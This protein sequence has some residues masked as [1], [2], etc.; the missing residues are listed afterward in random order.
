MTALLKDAETGVMSDAAIFQAIRPR[1]IEGGLISVI[2]TAYGEYGIVWETVAKQYNNPQTALA[3]RAPTLLLR[4]DKAEDYALAV[5]EDPQ[6]AEREYNCK[7]LAAAGSSF[8]DPAMIDEAVDTRLELPLQ[9]SRFGRVGVGVDTALVS[10]SSAFCAVRLEGDT[11]TVLELVELKPTKHRPLKLSEVCQVYSERMLAHGARSAA[12]D[13]HEL[14]ASKEHMSPGLTLVAAPGGQQA[15]LDQYLNVRV[16]L[17]AGRL[18]LPKGCERLIRQMKAI[19]AKPTPGG[20][21]KISSPRANLGGHG[22]LCSALCMAVHHVR[23]RSSMKVYLETME[24]PPERPKPF[25]PDFAALC[26]GTQ[27]NETR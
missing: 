16:L 26:G 21:I 19:T 5:K 3:C 4:P 15:K 14:E 8:F 18:K 7:P 22:D 11:V 13:H 24:L 27:E 10:D 23:A 25:R 20:G 17:N 2:S 6:N 9:R 1:L 12:A